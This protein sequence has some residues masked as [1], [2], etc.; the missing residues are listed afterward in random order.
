MED[1]IKRLKEDKLKRSQVEYKTLLESKYINEEKVF[2]NFFERYP[3]YLP[4]ALIPKRYILEPDENYLPFPGAVISQ[5]PLKSNQHYIPDFLWIAH[6]KDTV[7]PV[8]IEIEAP[9]KKW[10]NKNGTL[11]ADFTQAYHQ[12]MNWKNWFNEEINRQV[13]WKTLKIPY[14]ISKKSLVEPKFFLIYGRDEQFDSQEKKSIRKNMEIDGFHLLTYDDLKVNNQAMHLTTAKIVAGNYLFYNNWR[15]HPVNFLLTDTELN[16]GDQGFIEFM[17]PLIKNYRG[18]NILL[19]PELEWEKMN[20]FARA[21]PF[22]VITNK[23]RNYLE[24]NY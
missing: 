19:L 5:P 1:L 13:L 9:K 20:S 4:G 18:E 17:K 7:Y 22:S 12:L 6:D 23:S 24:K 2:Q 16:G 8:F 21:S 11:S 10:F 14:F 3:Y 15:F